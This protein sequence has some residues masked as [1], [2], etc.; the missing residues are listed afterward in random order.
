[1]IFPKLGFINVI[2]ILENIGSYFSPNVVSVMEIYAQRKKQHA[3]VCPQ[4]FIEQGSMED[5]F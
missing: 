5:T 2:F 3:W 1:M 4:V